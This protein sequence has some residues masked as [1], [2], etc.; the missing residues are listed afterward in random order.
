MRRFYLTGQRTFG[1]RGC[2]AIVRS[3]VGLLKDQFGDD[4]KVLVP[5]D[6][7][8]RD[9][10]QWPEASEQGVE[11]VQAYMPSYT[12]FW[13]NFQRLP[14]P[15]I[16]RA[17]WP[18]PMPSWLEEQIRSVDA[19]LS[20]GG[21]NYSLDYRLPSLLMGIDRLALNLGKPVVIWGAS[22]GPFELEPDF[23]STI[24]KHL[25]SIN[26][27]AVRESISYQYLTQGL[28][29]SNVIQ[30][31]DPAFTLHKQTVDIKPFWPVETG[32]GVLGI[33]ISPL[34]ERYKK[35]GQNLRTETA[36]FIRHVVLDEGMA[37]LLIPHI[38]PLNGSYKN[39]D[40]DYMT[41]LLNELADLGDAVKMMPHQFNASQIKYVISNLRFFIGART[42]A[43]IAA[44]SSSIPT[45]SI[46][47]SVKAKGIN[48]DLFGNEAAVLPTPEV[49]KKTLQTAFEWLLREEV[50]LKDTLAI[51]IPELQKS[52]ILA[53]ASVK[54]II[55]G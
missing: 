47:Y 38:T 33:N 39:S 22:V 54:E 29:L 11:F 40:A 25:S 42:H 37:V 18:F 41:V 1:N 49:S 7:I 44:L 55:N 5:S 52:A 26:M 12:R 50:D 27:I 6:D 45:V 13:V 17:G 4:I 43:T 31:A 2:E 46:A 3:T 9:S 32:N 10:A 24:T 35:V 15:G 36:D 48:K 19:V 8:A 34:I 30:M 51:R 53:T 14:I 21:D 20:V 23:V 28:G 16:K